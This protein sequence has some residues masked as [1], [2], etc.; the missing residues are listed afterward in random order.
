MLKSISIKLS[1]EETRKQMSQRF[2]K[3][4]MEHKRIKCFETIFESIR[5]IVDNQLFPDVDEYNVSKYID[6]SL[7]DKLMIECSRKNLIRD[8]FVSKKNRAIT[9]LL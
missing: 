1:E 7:R 8:E 2:S 9:S 6:E 5:D 3:F 4:V